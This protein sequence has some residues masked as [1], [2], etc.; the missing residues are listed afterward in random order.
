MTADSA[1]LVSP[2]M[3]PGE[4]R[5]GVVTVDVRDQ[6]RANRLLRCEIWYPTRAM[7]LPGPDYESGIPTNALRDAAVAR[8]PFPLVLF[9]HA[10]AA[11]REQS[12]FLTEFL[13]T[14]GYVVISP[15]H[16]HNTGRDFRPT[17]LIQSALDRPKD[18]RVLLDYLAQR[19]GTKG[20]PFL[21][22]IDVGRVGA[23]GQSLGG[24][25]ALAI[26]GVHVDT[27]T[28]APELRGKI[29]IG[30]H[31][32]SDP[33]VRIAV[34]F[35]PFCKPAF[36][37]EGLRHCQR[38]VLVVAGTEDL[39]TPLEKSQVPIFQNLGGPG[40]LAIIEG[41]THFSFNNEEMITHAPFVVRQM[42][43]PRID[44][45]HCEDIIRA[46]TL[47]FLEQ[48]L[49]DHIIPSPL[50]RATANLRVDHRPA[51]KPSPPLLPPVDAP[52]TFSP[53]KN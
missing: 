23:V 46:I 7:G 19:T 45:A 1:V 18:M 41:A 24:Y 48:H 33:R 49:R 5:A 47:A 25:T 16:P 2:R 9:S 29:P 51:Q 28:I 53:S 11:V 38:P 3:E 39:V 43:R 22:L 13:A 30:L 17:E 50:T 36:S 42:H 26:A 31:D 10:M 37:P 52:D 21:G 6:A 8:G 35:A 15:D 44:R 40:V 4:Y 14:H 34:A 20:D 27:R 12:T 32:F